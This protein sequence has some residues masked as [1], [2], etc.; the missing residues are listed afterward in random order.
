MNYYITSRLADPCSM[1][2]RCSTQSRPSTVIASLRR[3]VM[4]GPE[5]LSETSVII[6]KVVRLRP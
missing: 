1:D 4:L 6:K 5:R 2:K 3:A